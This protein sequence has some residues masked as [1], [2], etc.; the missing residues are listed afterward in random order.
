MKM[1]V[2]GAGSMGRRRLRDLSHLNVGEVLLFEPNEKRCREV[3]AALGLRGFTRFDQALAE[4]PRI[5]AISSPPTQ[6]AEYVRAG[7]E[8]E[9]H[10]FAEVPFVYTVR[11]LREIAAKAAAYP[12]VLAVSCTIRYWPPY[13]LIRDRLAAGAIGKPLYIEYSLGNHIAEWHPYENYRHFYASDAAMGGAGM[14]MIQHDLNP[15]VWWLG[16][17]ESV[18]A[19]FSKVSSL[20]I[21]GP[22]C[23]DMLLTFT[24]GARGYFHDDIIEPG[25]LGR[26]VRI[27][28]E[29]GTIEWH[30]NQPTVRI[31]DAARQATRYLPFT[32]AADWAEAE[33]A[34]REVA[35]ILAKGRTRSGQIPS[36]EVASY[37]YETNYFREMKDFVDAALGKRPYAMSSIPEE[38]RIMQTFEAIVK[39]A[40]QHREVRVEAR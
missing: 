38:L 13:R 4:S 18:H 30:Q 33:A 15:I 24:G 37:N 36:V 12:S 3:A 28:G 25:T 21:K 31:Y 35:Q 8:R 14:D 22:D 2:V 6:H 34:N 23:Q 19:R 9:M 40:E 39:S 10:I 20:D 32:D 17:V 16:D 7:M 1:L 11:E 26:H 27:V 5:M 29:S